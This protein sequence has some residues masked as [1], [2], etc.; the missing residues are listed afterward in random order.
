MTLRLIVLAAGVLAV[1]ACLAAG[2]LLGRLQIRRL[3]LAPDGTLTAGLLETPGAGPAI[4]AFS[5]PGCAS[6]KAEQAPALARLRA[7]EPSVQLVHVDVASRPEIARRFGILTVPSTVV[8][9]ASG[10]VLAANH[11][12][13]GADLL[14][15]QLNG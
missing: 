7:A 12:P 6:C 4:I 13:A 5:A 10:Q 14:R 1:L 8:V 15:A 3:E 2:R 9:S 11:G